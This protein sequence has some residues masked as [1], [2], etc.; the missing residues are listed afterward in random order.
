MH[1]AFFRSVVESPDA[2]G[3]AH[4][5]GKGTPDDCY[6]GHFPRQAWAPV[7]G[8]P[9]CSGAG[10]Q[11]GSGQGAVRVA[12]VGA[13]RSHRGPR[14]L[15]RGPRQAAPRAQ[16]ASRRRPPEG[17][18]AAREGWL[19]ECRLPPSGG[20][21]VGAPSR[22]PTRLGRAGRASHPHL[23]PALR[24]LHRI[25]LFQAPP[26][27]QLRRGTAARAWLR[28]PGAGGRVRRVPKE[29]IAGGYPD[30]DTLSASGPDLR[31]VWHSPGF[32]RHCRNPPAPA[33]NPPPLGVP[34][35]SFDP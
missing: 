34:R 10:A 18:A 29:G 28:E 2:A 23:T 33:S 8:L 9:G 19:K 14:A 12:L 16:G 5:G 17:A 31:N 1:A 27:G 4:L 30:P 6:A 11:S 21:N 24:A 3:G 35:A 13:R 22:G 20:G 15:E 32:G 25:S 7:A 26:R